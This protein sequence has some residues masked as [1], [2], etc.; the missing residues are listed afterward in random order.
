MSMTPMLSW[1]STDR[2]VWWN[3]QVK[4]VD[5]VIHAASDAV[6]PVTMRKY[7]QADKRVAMA[8]RSALLRALA[9][10]EG[11]YKRGELVRTE[12]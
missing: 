10:V 8:H 9:S 6:H 2:G 12:W 11:Q 5:D 3:N 7:T 4:R 1:H